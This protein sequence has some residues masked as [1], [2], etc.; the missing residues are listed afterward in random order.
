MLLMFK[1]TCKEDPAN[2][3]HR[4]SP[5][6]SNKY[7]QGFFEGGFKARGISPDELKEN[8]Y[9]CD[10]CEYCGNKIHRE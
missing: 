5:R 7:P 6:Y 4:Y 10:I 9:E 3:H 1:K 2:G 8:I